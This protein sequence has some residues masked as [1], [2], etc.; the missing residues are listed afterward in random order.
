[1]VLGTVE[2]WVVGGDTKA[3]R[4]VGHCGSCMSHGWLEKVEY[5]G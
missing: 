3:T 2:W 1:M 4:I 5:D